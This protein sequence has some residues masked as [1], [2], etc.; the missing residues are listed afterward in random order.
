MPSASSMLTLSMHMLRTPLGHLSNPFPAMGFMT[1]RARWSNRAWLQCLKG[2]EAHQGED[3]GGLVGEPGEDEAGAQAVTELQDGLR[4]RF[5]RNAKAPHRA[6]HA[7]KRRPLR[8]LL[9]LRSPTPSAM[10]VLQDQQDQGFRL[11]Y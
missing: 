6:P 9:Q 4:L 3:V 11:Y 10:S 2:L 8:E 7:L 5:S 1:S